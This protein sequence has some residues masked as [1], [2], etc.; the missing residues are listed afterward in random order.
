M[1][2]S[3][4]EKRIKRQMFEKNMNTAPYFHLGFLIDLGRLS[5]GEFR[6]KIIRIHQ[7]PLLFTPYQDIFP[8][9]SFFGF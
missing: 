5:F 1:I 2:T 8:H 4:E 3:V 9:I 6:E 7:F